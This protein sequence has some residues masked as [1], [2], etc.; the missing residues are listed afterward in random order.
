MAHSPIFQAMFTNP[1]AEEFQSGTIK[2]TDIK[3]SQTMGRFF[4]QSLVRSG[5]A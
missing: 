4:F 1:L 3:E 5:E 2:I